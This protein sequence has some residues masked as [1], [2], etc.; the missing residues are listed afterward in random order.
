LRIIE[1]QSGRVLDDQI[2]HTKWSDVAWLH[3][4]DG[5]YYRR[6]PREGEPNFDA[7]RQDAYHTRLFF[8]RLGED[9]ARDTLVYSPSSPTDFPGASVSD[10]DRWVVINNARGWSQSDVFLLD[11]G[12]TARGRVEVPDA[13]HPLVTV[14]AGEDHLTT[15]RV[16]D[17]R[18]YLHTN[19]GAPRYRLAAVDVGQ[20]AARSAWADVIP[21]G[22]GTLDGWVVAGDRLLA[23]VLTDVS[24]TVQVHFRD[25]RPDGEIA[26]PGRGELGSLDADPETGR[27]LIGFSGFVHAPAMHTWTVGAGQLTRLA[28]VDC[29]VDLSTLEVWQARVPSRDGTLVPVSLVGRRDLVRDGRVPVLLNGYG[30]FNV[31]LL[32]GFQ[33]HPL[34]WVERGFVFAVANLRGGGEFGEDWHRAG[35]L[36]NKERVFEDM[37]AVLRWLSSS[38]LSRPERIAITGGSNGGLLMGAM[39]TRAP[40]AFAASAAYVG[41][42]DMV[43]YH[44]FPPAELWV[45]EYGSSDDAAQFG[46]L[47]AYSPYHRVLDGTR[48]PAVLIETADHDTR[49]HW[50]HSTKFAAR[51]QEA[52]GEAD[53]RVW[54]HREAQ[55]G[56]GAGTRLSDVVARYARMY[57]F[58]EH[59]LEVDDDAAHAAASASGVTGGSP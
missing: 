32:P 56:H 19:E 30:G 34:Y 23:H 50:G 46:W 49:V 9:P 11:R 42:Y 47:H 22:P 5:F 25:G 29:P 36:A 14:V 48:F 52:S 57:S 10:D 43:R 41:L 1:V 7:E 27:A 28:Q 51:L 33:R 13:S 3:A 55:V 20:A 12:R 16:H 4:E 17:G 35:N 24:S 39:I 38:G 59:A 44:R 53:P 45:S 2:G 58:V 37:E 18:L 8:H 15:G 31:S 26:L 6:Y 54:F 40:E 21:Q